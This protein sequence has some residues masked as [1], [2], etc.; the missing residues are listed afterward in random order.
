MEKERQYPINGI[1]E[2]YFLEYLV[3]TFEHWN[4]LR[5]EKVA[6]GTR[7]IAKFENVVMGAKMNSRFGFEAVIR[8]G[9]LDKDNEE[10][11]IL[12]IYRNREKMEAK[13]PLY[14]FDTKI[15]R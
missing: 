4:R 7:E 10:H 1:V 11:Y 14:S 3:S 12:L 13:E 5:A 6:L 9:I 15:Y 2:P 8:R